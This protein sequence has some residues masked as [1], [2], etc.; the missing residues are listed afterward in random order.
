VLGRRPAISKLE[1]AGL[2]IGS[3][4]RIALSRAA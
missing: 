3:L 2:L 4:V 1:R